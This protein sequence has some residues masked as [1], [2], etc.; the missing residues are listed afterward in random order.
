MGAWG[1]ASPRILRARGAGRVA[2]GGG[3]AGLAQNRTGMSNISLEEAMTVVAEKDDPDKKFTNELIDRECKFAPD[4]SFCRT[5][6]VQEA[7]RFARE[8]EQSSRA[9]LVALKEFL[10]GLSTIEGPKAIVFLSG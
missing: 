3:R 1:R 10:N 8:L 6:V 7:A 4:A 2:G 9:S 5:R